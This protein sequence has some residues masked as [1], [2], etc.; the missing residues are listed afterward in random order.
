M[1]VPSEHPMERNN[2]DIALRARINYLEKR[3]EALER[4]LPI[5]TID[6]VPG[7]ALGREGMLVGQK[8][9]LRLWLLIDGTWRY[10]TLT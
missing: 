7:G 6:G 2:P 5:P 3:V 4:G 8:T 9:P 10:T 1:A